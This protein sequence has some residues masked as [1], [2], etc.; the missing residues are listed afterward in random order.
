M[1]AVNILIQKAI[2]REHP[3]IVTLLGS[4]DII[5]ALILQNVFTTKRSNM[6]ALM[7]SIL[8]IFSVLILG[9]AKFIN[10]REKK[11]NIE[12]TEQ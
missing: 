1:I 4:A 6:F 9:L 8:V 7:G 10:D 11:A 3:A 12:S 2:K 5:F